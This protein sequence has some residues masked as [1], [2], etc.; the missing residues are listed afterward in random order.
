MHSLPS[1][2]GQCHISL[3]LL[4]SFESESCKLISACINKKLILR[5]L[6]FVLHRIDHEG[7]ITIAFARN[8]QKLKMSVID[9]YFDLLKCSNAHNLPCLPIIVKHL[10]AKRQREKE[11]K[12]RREKANEEEISNTHASNGIW[13]RQ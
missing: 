9:V 10:Q 11:E 4:L 5:F 3:F 2:K 7:S 6:S 1:R 8:L 13:P 12:K